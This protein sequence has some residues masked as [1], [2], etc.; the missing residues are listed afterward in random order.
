MAIQRN[1]KIAAAG[2]AGNGSNIESASGPKE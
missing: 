1:G 2:Y